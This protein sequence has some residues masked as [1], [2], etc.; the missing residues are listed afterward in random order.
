MVTSPTPYS[1]YRLLL[2]APR[3]GLIGCEFCLASHRWR[4]LNTD[5][6]S[7]YRFKLSVEAPDLVSM[8]QQ[9]LSWHPLSIVPLLI[10]FS[11]I[12]TTP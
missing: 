3:V 7:I 12:I 6:C 2:T 8:R 4:V 5:V 9:V 11:W 10:Y 1:G